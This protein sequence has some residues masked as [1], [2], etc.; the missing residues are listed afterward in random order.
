[1]D[2]KIIIDLPNGDKLVA[3]ECPHTGGQIAIGIMR[4]NMWIQDLAVVETE[5][6]E[7]YTEDKFNVYVYG[8]EYDECYTERFEINRVPSDAL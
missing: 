1:M 7:N 3:E 2:Q 4:D 6:T 5:G 8:S